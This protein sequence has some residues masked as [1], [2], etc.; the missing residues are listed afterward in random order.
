MNEPLI[1]LSPAAPPPDGFSVPVNVPVTPDVLADVNVTD[2][3]PMVGS[4]L[5]SPALPEQSCARARYCTDTELPGRLLSDA[6]VVPVIAGPVMMMS[7]PMLTS[8]AP[9]L[10]VAGACPAPGA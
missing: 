6:V 2:A 10:N 8:V 5:H 1:V 4:A 9:K 3:E 7:E